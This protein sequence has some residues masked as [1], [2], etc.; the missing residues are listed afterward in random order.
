MIR[1][2][3]N[4]GSVALGAAGGGLALITGIEPYELVLDRNNNHDRVILDIEA[5]GDAAALLAHRGS[6]RELP[7]HWLLRQV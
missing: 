4:G 2:C 7:L 6:Y 1:T 5:L 3:V